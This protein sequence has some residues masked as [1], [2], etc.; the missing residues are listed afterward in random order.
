MKRRRKYDN[1]DSV[2]SQGID[3]SNYP[4]IPNYIRDRL[5]DPVYDRE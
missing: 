1:G 2:E 3:F 4:F 5:N